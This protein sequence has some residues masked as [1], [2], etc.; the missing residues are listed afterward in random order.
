MLAPVMD[1]LI[2]VPV[3]DGRPRTLPYTFLTRRKKPKDSCRLRF[4]LVGNGRLVRYHKHIPGKAK[5]S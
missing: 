4:S 5:K 2:R 1:I 3:G